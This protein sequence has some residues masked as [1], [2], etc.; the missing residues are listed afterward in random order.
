META[1]NEKKRK[2]E[3]PEESTQKKQKQGRRRG[4]VFLTLDTDTDFLSPY[5]TSEPAEKKPIHTPASLA[6]DREHST[7]FV[8]QLPADTSE[9]T[10]QALFT[11]V[12]LATISHSLLG[13]AN[14]L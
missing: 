3:K 13:F 10:L 12:R 9:E 11:D 1:D 8:G 6:R 2:A 4:V 7:V 5:F 14:S